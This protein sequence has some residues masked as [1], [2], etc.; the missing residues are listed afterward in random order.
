MSMHSLC[1]GGEVSQ[2]VADVIPPKQSARAG[3]DVAPAPTHEAKTNLTHHAGGAL[4]L[5]D[6]D[7]GLRPFGAARAQA[8]ALA[9]SHGMQQLPRWH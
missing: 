7:V 8:L 4:A 9:P 1:S 2:K 3:A 6:A 5:R